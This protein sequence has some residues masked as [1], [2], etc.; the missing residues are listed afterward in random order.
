LAK[1]GAPSGHGALVI[2]LII[3]LGDADK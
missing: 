3:D 2:F 1:A